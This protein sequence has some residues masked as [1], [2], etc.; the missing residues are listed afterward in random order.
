MSYNYLKKNIKNPYVVTPLVSALVISLT[1]LDGQITDYASD[2]NPIFG[3]NNRAKNYSDLVTFLA[4]P[5]ASTLSTRLVEKNNFST[6]SEFLQYSTIIIAPF[7]T[8]TLN[9]LLKNSSGRL[10]PDLS[11]TQSFPSSHTGMASALS[12]QINQNAE[13][14]Y[15]NKNITKNTRI[16]TEALTFSVAWARMEARKHHLTDVLVGYSI[17]K[18]FG[19]F[20]H[21]LVFNKKYS[22][23]TSFNFMNKDKINMGAKWN[24]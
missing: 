14:I 22:I 20:F 23:R 15:H 5:I 8:L 10:R 2:Y 7:V 17:G 16:M 3:S 24:F 11:D 12:E 9:S 1:D 19:L 18:F 21:D 13:L 4:L 6:R